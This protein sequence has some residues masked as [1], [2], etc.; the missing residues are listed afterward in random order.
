MLEISLSWWGWVSGPEEAT[1]NPSLMKLSRLAD[2]QFSTCSYLLSKR[3]GSYRFEPLT[4]DRCGLSHGVVRGTYIKFFSDFKGPLP[5]FKTKGK[6]SQPL[7]WGV[8][9]GGI[10][11]LQYL[12]L[13][14][15]CKTSFP[16]PKTQPVLVDVGQAGW[17]CGSG[18]RVGPLSSW[19]LLCKVCL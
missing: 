10:L 15:Y 17:D 16:S 6:A 18:L 12:C 5:Q 3:L 2:L 7:N 1:F 19:C 14:N 8:F 11:A 4:P 9:A 13:V